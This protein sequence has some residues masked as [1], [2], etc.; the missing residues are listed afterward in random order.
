MGRPA[1]L[2]MGKVL[3]IPGV[4]A[5]QG[6]RVQKVHDIVMSPKPSLLASV[7]EET[8]GEG[9]RDGTGRA[10]SGLHPITGPPTSV[11]SCE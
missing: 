8:W 7:Q 1:V 5:L 3:Y 2:A 9:L 6:T 10:S 4:F 11:S